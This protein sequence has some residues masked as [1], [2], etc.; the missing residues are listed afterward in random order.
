MKSFL[1]I[2]ILGVFLSCGQSRKDNT[3]ISVVK[4]FQE[5]ANKNKKMAQGI[6][7]ETEADNAVFVIKGD[8]LYYFEDP[9]PVFFKL[10]SERF[11]VIIDGEEYSNKLI[12]LTKDSLI[13]E[14]DDGL[15]KLYKRN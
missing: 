6:W 13:F 14:T 15:L 12:K 7:A 2:T 9:I 1:I 4:E 3:N 10:T 8:S 11:N 5:D